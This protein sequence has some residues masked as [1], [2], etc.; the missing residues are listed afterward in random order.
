MRPYSSDISVG[1]AIYPSVAANICQST[2]NVTASWRAHEPMG[3]DMMKQS[4]FVDVNDRLWR[5][6]DLGDQV[7]A[8]GAAVDFEMFRAGLGA[9]LDYS[10]GSK[11]GRPPYYAALRPLGIKA[12]RRPTVYTAF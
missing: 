11:G 9:A 5:P 6:S 12:S 10:Y 7:G 8:F 1:S 3:D 4:G 2:S